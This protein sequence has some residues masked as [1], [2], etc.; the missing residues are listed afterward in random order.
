MPLS[1]RVLAAPLLLFAAPALAQSP[2]D[3]TWKVDLASAKVE[4]K[5]DVLLLKN[6]VYTCSTCMPAYS[7]KAD[8][9]FHAVPGNDYWDETA[10]TIVDDHTVKL[11]FKKGG[12]LIGEGTNAVSPNGNTATRTSHNTN[13]GG[14]VPVDSTA[15]ITRVGA[16]VA[17]AHLISGQWRPAPPK[18][19]S[20]QAMTM[21]MSVSGGMAHMKTGLGESL[22][23]KIGGDYALNA[24]D[25]GKTMTKVAQPD[26]KTLVMTDMRGGKVVQVST[27]TVDDGVLRA[28]W[29]DPRDGAKGGF[30]ATRQ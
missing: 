21:T 24:G 16:P 14:G 15:V 13:N 18:S 2:F 4:A 1:L 19:V 3:G 20:D 25:P 17:G 9:A 22:D 23:A 28:T 8:G 10:V 12:K 5:P 7:V 6:S 26:P 30:T 27:Y 11:A 29:S